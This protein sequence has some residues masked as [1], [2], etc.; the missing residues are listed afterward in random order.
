MSNHV[1]CLVTQCQSLRARAVCALEG[2]VW[3]KLAGPTSASSRPRPTRPLRPLQLLNRLSPLSPS[4]PSQRLKTVISLVLHGSSAPIRRLRVFLCSPSAFLLQ[5]I[6]I[7]ISS[8]LHLRRLNSCR[9]RPLAN[10]GSAL[11][12]LP[13][14][15]NLTRCQP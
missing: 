4:R 5:I 3:L 15:P 13:T 2:S 12:D 11:A 14:Q 9:L 8:R 6:A 1:W 10:V 7:S